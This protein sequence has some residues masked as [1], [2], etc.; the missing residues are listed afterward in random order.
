V[1]EVGIVLGANINE[2]GSPTEVLRE[3]LDAAIRLQE[4]STIKKIVVSNTKVA[5]FAMEQYLLDQGIDPNSIAIDTNAVITV[6]T[7][8]AEKASHPNNRRIIFISQGFHLPRLL[9]LCKQEGVSGVGF[10]AEEVSLLD[11]QSTSALEKIYIRSCRYI[12]E[13]ALSWVGIF[14]SI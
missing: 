3:R 4:S 7:C 2:D 10:A 6:D 9:F 13:A 11:D 14:D 5:A 12:R 8:R 1:S